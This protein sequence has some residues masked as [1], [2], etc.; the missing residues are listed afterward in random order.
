MGFIS[1]AGI[2]PGMQIRYNNEPF[3]VAK[4]SF[5][6]Q[7]RGVGVAKTKLRNLRTGAVVAV[8]FQ[9]NDQIEEI[10]LESKEAQFLYTDDTVAYFMDKVS[11]EQFEI[12][13]TI[14]EDKLPF[15]KEGSDAEILLYDDQ[16]LTVNLPIKIELAVKEAP[17]GI[18][19]DTQG[20]GSKMVTM[21]TG[22]QVSTP[23]FINT[24]DILRIDTRDGS[25]VE[26]AS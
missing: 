2:K 16:P 11:Y 18:K 25:Y 26:R 24:G 19:G 15:M 1:L 22:L 13:K 12:A 4:S 17:P 20:G 9:G 5:A 8:S 14:L 3:E 7:G 21:E 6:K 10:T 23:L